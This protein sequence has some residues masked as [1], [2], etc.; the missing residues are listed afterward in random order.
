MP[1]KKEYSHYLCKDC[2]FDFIVPAILKRKVNCP[3]CADSIYV[4]KLMDLWLER[5]INYKR[6]W[7][8]EEDELITLGKEQGYTYEQMSKSLLGR[9]PQ[10]VRRRLQNI[11]KDEANAGV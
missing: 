8:K 10:S 3:K 5:P 2:E 4:E 11:R 9:S 6:P 1:K 7:T